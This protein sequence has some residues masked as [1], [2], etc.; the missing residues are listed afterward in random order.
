MREAPSTWSQ[1]ESSALFGAMHAVAVGGADRELTRVEKGLIEGAA[2]HIFDV[3]GVD[4]DA[5]TDVT[6]DEL[7]AAI[8]DP[9]HRSTAIQMLVLVPYADTTV[10]SPEVAV[11]DGYADALG[12]HPNTLRDLHQV[13]DLHI[14]RLLVDYG[15]RSIGAF[16][17][18]TEYGPM[19]TAARFIHQYIGDSHVTERWTALEGYPEGSLGHTFFVF[20]RDRGF[21]LPGEHHGTG[22]L[23]VGHDSS[24]ILSG[25][26]TDGPSELEVAGFEAGMSADG[27]GYE[28]LL[29]VI[30]DYHMGIDFGASSV[31]IEPKT[32]EFDPD[33]VTTGI[34]RGI[35]CNVDLIR[36]WD[37]WSVADVPVLEL[38]ERY[39]IL[40]D[41]PAVMEPPEF[42][43]T[44]WH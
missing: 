24:H 37:F 16:S 15:R 36:D 4:A 30:L 31:G 14:K 35:D 2:E 43:R 26:N 5:L 1:S 25:T 38:R 33:R 28:M 8:T 29:E 20:Y 41:R 10:D 27:F 11:V 18:N 44:D 42:Q 39:N 40:G 22:E 6:P 21:P 3:D 12:Q 7:A 17:E 19:R 23:F 32:G 9:E 13:R 34:R